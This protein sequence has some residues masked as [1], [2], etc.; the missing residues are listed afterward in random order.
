MQHNDQCDVCSERTPSSQ[1]RA[2]HWNTSTK[3]LAIAA[4]FSSFDSAVV[5]LFF[6]CCYHIFPFF[7]V[8]HQFLSYTLLPRR[9]MCF[10]C[11]LL[12]ALELLQSVALPYALRGVCVSISRFNFNFFISL[13]ILDVLF[14]F[15][16]F[17]VWDPLVRADHLKR[18]LFSPLVG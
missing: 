16:H 11:I 18:V 9:W 3:V 6:L 13:Y 8:C 15:D 7:S 2:L 1:S 14:C 10:V 5:L 4:V 17:A 12:C